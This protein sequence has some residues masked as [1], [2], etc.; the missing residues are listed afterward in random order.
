MIT[1]GNIKAE[2]LLKIEGMEGTYSV[3]HIEIPVNVSTDEKRPL[4]AN[5]RAD[6]SGVAR[7]LEKSVDGVSITVDG[8]RVAGVLRNGNIHYTKENY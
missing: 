7:S 6:T 8:T 1:V 2:V 4:H 3:G 5:V